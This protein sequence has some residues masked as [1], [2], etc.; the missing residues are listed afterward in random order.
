MRSE[1]FKIQPK[2]SSYIIIT[3]YHN[4]KSSNIVLLS[5]LKFDLSNI[6]SFDL[7]RLNGLKDSNFLIWTGVR[8]AVPKQLR[9]RGRKVNRDRIQHYN[10]KKVTIFLIQHFQK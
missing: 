7:A 4:Y 5:D 1:N 6:K 3:Y 8:S 10:F 2:F 9:I